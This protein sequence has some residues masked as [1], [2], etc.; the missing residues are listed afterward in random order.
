M[1]HKSALAEEAAK[2]GGSKTVYRLINEMIGTKTNRTN[3][4]KDENRVLLIDPL[5]IDERWA[6]HFKSLLKKPRT[7]DQDIIPDAP[8]MILYVNKE[9]T[10]PEEII[11]TIRTEECQDYI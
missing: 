7:I 4:V 2:K 3:L 6:T 1:E 10:S 5:K 9:P 8:L 11:A